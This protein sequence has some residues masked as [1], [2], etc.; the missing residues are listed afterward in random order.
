MKTGTYLNPGLR[1]ESTGSISVTETGPTHLNRPF[2]ACP[3]QTYV[4][5]I[6]DLSDS[7]ERLA[8]LNV[9]LD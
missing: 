5:V 4:Q 8:R 1:K 9:E 3:N 7:F 6:I 2:H